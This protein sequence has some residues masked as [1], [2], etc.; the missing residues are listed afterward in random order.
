[1]L[2]RKDRFEAVNAQRE[3][4]GEVLFANPRN[5]A[6][7][8]LRMKDPRRVAERSLEAFVYQVGFAVDAEGQDALH[9]FDTHGEWVDALGELGFM[10]PTDGRK[11]CKDIEEVAAFCTEWEERRDSYGYEIDGMVVKVNSLDL[12]DECGYTSHHPRW[13]VAYK[14]K[15]KQAT[16]TLLDVEFNVGKVG[17]VTP[18]AKL[19]PVALAGVTISNVSLHNEEFIISKDIRIGDRV[20]VERAGDV[21]PYIVQ[22]MPDLRD[23]S[24]RVVEYPRQCPSCSTDLVKPEAEAVWRC[25]NTDCPAQFVRRLEHFVSK[26]GMDIDGFGEAN[27]HKFYELG[28]LRTLADVFRLEYDAIADL[29]GMG[30]KSADKLRRAIDQAKRNPISRLLRSLSVHHLGPRAS[31]LIAATIGHVLELRER[32]VEDLTAIKDIGPV[33]AQNVVAFFQ[34]DHN[35]ELLQEMESLGV[36]LTQ[37]EADR[38]RAVVTEGAFVGKT[39][40]FTGSLQEMTRSQAKKKAEAAGAKVVSA[41]SKKL[42]VL[43]AGEKA[44]SKLTKAEALGTVEILTEAEFL[45]RVEG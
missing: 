23:G 20:L 17:S 37:T 42:D 8:G 44:G 45:A 34:N 11:V 15:A 6:T 27:V 36:N 13:A 26:Q 24:E 39:V 2:I 32:T 25:V 35:V 38:P 4:A 19:E 9:R 33:V 22:S 29:E 21:I 14:F 18:V 43:V 28:W 7:G 30:T 41:V 1:M 40:V 31:T 5:A 12:Q 16:T 3:E 10:V